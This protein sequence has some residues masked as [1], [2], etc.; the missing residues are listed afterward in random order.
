ME[1]FVLL[2]SCSF[3]LIVLNS[4]IIQAMT[5]DRSK[6]YSECSAHKV[7]LENDL[8]KTVKY[9]IGYLAA[10]NREISSIEECFSFKIIL[11]DSVTVRQLN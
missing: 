1:V 4:N 2:G 10:S 7:D 6:Q 11:G 9:D 8:E 5:F 3:I